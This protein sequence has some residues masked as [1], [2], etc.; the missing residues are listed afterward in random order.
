MPL[1]PHPGKIGLQLRL[2]A[3]AI[4]GATFGTGALAL[5]LS[6]QLS[7]PPLARAAS[8]PAELPVHTPPPEPSARTQG[9]TTWATLLGGLDQAPPVREAQAR[10][11]AS[12][13]VGQQSEARAWWPRLDA[14]LRTDQQNQRYNGIASRTPSS[15]TTLQATMPLWRPAERADARADAAV[16]EQ[17]QWQAR[18]RRQSLARTL[19]Q[20]YLDAVEAAEQARLTHAHLAALAQQAQ[21]HQKRLQAGLGTVVDALET[22]ARQEQVL[23]QAEQLRARLRTLTLTLNR[24]SGLSVLPPDGLSPDAP[25]SADVPLPPLPEALAQVL[26]SHPEV[27]DA[28]AGVRASMESLRA[29]D[30][31]RWQPTLD[32]IASRGRT[33]QT[34]RFEGVSDRQDIRSD[35][36]GLVLNWPLFS[37]GLQ[38]AR[39]REAAALL[40]AAQARLDDAEARVGTDLQDAYQR[41]EQARYREARQASVV[42]SMQAT[43][44]AL[45]K[46]WLA[47]LRSTTDLLG[48]QQ[49]LHEAR[50]AWVSA[51][52]DTLQ[53]GSDA[54]ALL[55]QLDAPHIAPWLALFNTAPSPFASSMP[56]MP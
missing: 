45:Q 33:R 55:G 5:T 6:Q 30:A 8:A 2:C 36:V 54:L 21:A 10:A 56:A 27:L 51:R 9:A 17:A 18:L 48:A 28:Q 15:S 47:G 1:A 46:A 35:A 23:A 24:L 14:N 38:Q 11:E 20:Q 40:S 42:R 3:T 50:L 44:N 7:W 19:S 37:G 43:L 26:G 34:Q 41:H 16:A 29:R 13:A 12:S 53:A 4:I 25:D 52:V 49:R 32:A 31:E 39:Q 22:Q